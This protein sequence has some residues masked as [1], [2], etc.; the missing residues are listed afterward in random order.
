MLPRLLTEHADRLRSAWCERANRN[1]LV[2][3]LFEGPVDPRLVDLLLQ[4]FAG[5]LAQ[6][7]AAVP[8]GS[9]ERTVLECSPNR[10]PRCDAVAWIELLAA[11]REVLEEFLEETAARKLG[12]CYSC[13]EDMLD[14]LETAFRL[15]VHK[16]L[17]C[18]CEHCLTLMEYG[19]G[20][21]AYA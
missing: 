13:T 1:P 2:M 8:R 7:D 20:R 5:V 10:D 18:L 15:M 12:S 4:E 11:G 17:Q 6:G 19:A 16:R 9:P 14:D 21:A 3:G